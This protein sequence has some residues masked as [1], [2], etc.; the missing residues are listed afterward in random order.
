MLD[1]NGDGRDD[2]LQ[3]Q[4]PFTFEGGLY[5]RDPS[6]EIIYTHHDVAT[7][8]RPDSERSVQQVS[9][10]YD[11]DGD[12]CMDFANT[13]EILDHA[14]DGSVRST[15]NLEIHRCAGW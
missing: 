12:G 5:L 3:L 9:R 1:T 8:G 14:D 4:E 11:I 6:G 7:P 10:P 13:A 2:V 15:A